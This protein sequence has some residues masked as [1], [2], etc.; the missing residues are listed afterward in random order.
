MLTL[1][2]SAL[3][4]S[5]LAAAVSCTT[6]ANYLPA[7][8]IATEPD[9]SWVGG[10]YSSWSYWA[11]KPGTK[12]L[13]MIKDTAGA[14]NYITYAF[15]GVTT[16]KTLTDHL[17]LYGGKFL[18]DQ[19][20][21][22]PGTV[23]DTE[24]LVE[25]GVTSCP[26]YPED[27]SACVNSYATKYMSKYAA[28]TN[29]KTILLASIGGW[30]YT[31]RLNQFYQDYTSDPAVLT[32]FVDSTRNWLKGHPAFSGISIDWEYPGYGHSASHDGHQGEGK[33]Y[34]AMMMKLRIMLNNL[35]GENNKHYYLTTAVVASPK[36]AKG[37]AE[38]G[39]DW[40]KVA[41]S[42]DWLDLMGFDMHGEFDVVSGMK[43]LAQNMSES[44]ELQSAIDFYIKKAHVPARKIVLGGPTYAREML[45]AQQPTEKNRFGYM[46]SL[47]YK[48][49]EKYGQAFKKAY[50][51]DNPD[52]FKFADNPNPEPYYPAAGMV[53]FTGTYSYSCFLDTLTKGAAPSQCGF[54]VKRDNRGA[55][56]Q[57]I[58]KGLKLSY[59]EPNIAW[60]SD[61]KQSVK[62]TFAGAPNPSQPYPAYP[63]FTLDTQKVVRN[64]ANKLVKAN[65]LGGMWF[66]ELSQD[67]LQSPKYA[68]FTQACKSI[69]H[70]GMCLTEKNQ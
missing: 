69:G 64:K 26:E 15:L 23:V 20:Q 29:G 25:S 3:A 4:I 70:N 51:T 11:G 28:S 13:S 5:S 47:R 21:G 52:Y 41:S 48:G 66:W 38:E 1:R 30:S 67:A 46:G 19:Q 22:K 50:Y 62:A 34:T 40:Q 16:Q 31:D 61:N 32:R 56:G 49:F 39:V 63:V 37:E 17:P 35:G 68:L 45:V 6:L 36:K 14:A 8:A 58:P 2:T 65:K 9:G 33:L 53:D 54:L 10:Y 42:A 24:A 18:T 43:G 55:I 44:T 27:F 59:P 12:D 60:L 57:P 7:S